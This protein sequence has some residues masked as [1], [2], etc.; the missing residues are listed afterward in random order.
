MDRVFVKL[1]ILNPLLLFL[2]FGST[3]SRVIT[4]LMKLFQY[5]MPNLKYIS[6][7]DGFCFSKQ[8]PGV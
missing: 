6:H 7:M 3:F 4:I 2:F 8:Q 1:N 5:G